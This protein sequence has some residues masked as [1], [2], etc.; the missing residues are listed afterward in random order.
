MFHLWSISVEEQF[1]LFAPW[2]VKK[3]DRRSLS[4]FGIALIVSANVWLLF[5]GKAQAPDGA[6]WC[7]SFVQFENFAAGILLCLML[8]GI[9]PRIRAW[10]RP[11][12]LAA[13]A[14][15]WL[16]ASL[17]FHTHSGVDAVTSSLSL[18]GGYGLVAL[19]S[20]FLLI[21]FLGLDKKLLPSWAIYLG[22]ISYGLYVFHV[23]ALHFIDRVF[24]HF[25]ASWSVA[26][27]F[28]GATAMGFTILLASLS[29]RYFETPFLKIKR[30][31]EVIVS[32][33]V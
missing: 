30:Q 19:G 16:Y 32:R 8:H 3:L 6:I 4:G 7:N 11:A 22:R 20:C 2:A 18:I 17:G 9:T 29:Y 21:A 10:Q 14:L 28:K 15:C 1:Y 24:N 33:P 13:W 26:M 27:L 5:L 12:L 31:H 23:P 25:P